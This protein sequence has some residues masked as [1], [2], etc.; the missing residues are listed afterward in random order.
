MLA[1]HQS[2]KQTLPPS[3]FRTSAPVRPHFL[4]PTPS[5][6]TPFDTHGRPPRPPPPVAPNGRRAH[7]RHLARRGRRRARRARRQ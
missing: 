3:Y 5:R 6:P 4:S 1:A 2:T 7:V